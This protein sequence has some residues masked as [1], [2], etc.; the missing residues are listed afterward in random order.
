M[1]LFA[2]QNKHKQA[3]ISQLLA[4]SPLKVVFP[5]DVPEVMDLEVEETGASFEENALLKARAF[6]QE[7]N[8]LTAA[9]DTGLEVLAL[10]GKP[11]VHSKRFFPGTDH[12]RNQEL[13]RQLQPAPDRSARF[14]TVICVF[15][16]KLSEHTFFEGVVTGKI[17]ETPQGDQGFGY[18]PV[19]IPDGYDQTFAELGQEV[20]NSISHRRRALIKLH[21]F[22][23]QAENAVY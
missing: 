14:V 10:D 2:T 1:I 20:K 3:E 11:G 6:G 23:L 13:L 7:T 15:D 21:T 16:P 12:D 4:D 8:L 22:L 9:E 18:D 19:F 5:Q 17:S